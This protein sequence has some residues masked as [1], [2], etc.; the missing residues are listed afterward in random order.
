MKN[1]LG[2]DGDFA[3]GYVIAFAKWVITYK[4]AGH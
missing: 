2:A 3:Q 1:K 4:T